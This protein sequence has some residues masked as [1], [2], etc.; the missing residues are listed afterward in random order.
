[1]RRLHHVAPPPQILPRLRMALPPLLTMPLLLMLAACSGG[2]KDDEAAAAKPADPVAE[3]HS[4]A[5]VAGA[6]AATV[7]VY[8]VAEAGAGGE[9]T[10]IAPVEATVAAV[11][12]GLDD[13]S[14]GA[15]TAASPKTVAN[16]SVTASS[17]DSRAV[18]GH[19]HATVR[20]GRAARSGA[21]A[22]IPHGP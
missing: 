22:A 18:A 4:A 6:A 11:D 17:P 13:A 5:A 10:L 19:R 12:G 20:S 14:A 15:A 9:R 8:G 3:V 7:T 2:A 21:F 1:M 16:Q